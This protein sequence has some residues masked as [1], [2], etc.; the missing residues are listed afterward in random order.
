MR[1][2]GFDA[3]EHYAASAARSATEKDVHLAGGSAAIDAA[4]ATTAKGS[5]DRF[6]RPLR[7]IHASF[8]REIFGNPFRTVAV[9]SSWLTA[10]VRPLAAAVYEDRHMPSGLF[11]T[12]RLGI[13]ADTLEDA[14]CD[15]ADILNHCRQPGEHV[16]GC[17]ILDMV[18]G[19]E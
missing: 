3:P 19:K 2:F 7:P 10:N 16:R 5:V 12:H 6:H 1:R 15:N 14:G 8:L 9:N 17:W 11:D 13:L 18:L 4:L